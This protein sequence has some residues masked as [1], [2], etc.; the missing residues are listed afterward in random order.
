MLFLH[1]PK[2]ST[3]AKAK[4]WLDEH[5]LTYTERHIKEKN[6]S[7]K[8][9]KEWHKRSGMPLKK[10]FNTSGLVYKNLNLKDKLPALTEEEQYALLA[11]DGMLVK[12]PLII[13]DSCILTGF[14]EKEWEEALVKGSRS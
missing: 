13:S 9:L 14:K 6:P 8:E 1:Y 7:A 12:R 4:K 11:S 3:C 10:F 5:L 2:C